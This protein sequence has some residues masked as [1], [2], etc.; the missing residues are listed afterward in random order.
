MRRTYYVRVAAELGC[1]VTVSD[2]PWEG[3]L[4]VTGEDAVSAERIEAAA[5]RKLGLPL[6]IAETER[7]ELRELC[8]GDFEALRELRGEEAELKAAGLTPEL[9]SSRPYLEA[10]VRDQYRFFEYGLWGVFLRKSGG[11]AGFA[12]LSPGDP[13]ELGYYIRREYRRRGYAMEACRAVFSYAERELFLEELSVSADRTNAASLGLAGK[14][15]EWSGR[16]GSRVRLR[17][18]LL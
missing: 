7:L 15:A 2:E 13:P 16:E 9:L 6:L 18:R 4:S 10:Y 1:A 14:L 8:G 3:D 11:L 5:R 12:G 17:A